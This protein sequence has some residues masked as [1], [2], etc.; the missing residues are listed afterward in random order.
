MNY[1]SQITKSAGPMA[2]LPPGALDN[3]TQ[4]T[5]ETLKRLNQL[6]DRASGL[7]NRLLGVIP[8]DNPKSPSV[9]PV[10]S[11][12]VEKIAQ[13]ADWTVGIVQALSADLDRLEQL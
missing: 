8:Q 9:T 3:L 12:T 6:H 4:R 11:S 13:I 2:T 5:D 10:A 7:A 1:P